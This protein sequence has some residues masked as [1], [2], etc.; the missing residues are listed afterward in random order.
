[1]A[2]YVGAFAWALSW[3]ALGGVTDLEQGA[4]CLA[5]GAYAYL[6]DDSLDRGEPLPA[7]GAACLAVTL[8]LA[9]LPA[10]PLV[11]GFLPAYKPLKRALPLAKPLYVAA[12]WTVLC[13]AIPSPRL[14]GHQAAAEDLAAVFLL[15]AALSNAA[16]V[17]D[18]EED[19]E[20]GI[21]TLPTRVG[22]RRALGV[23][24]V[25]GAGAVT[26][27]ALHHPDAWTT[28]VP[29]ASVV[30]LFV[31]TVR[32]EGEGCLADQPFSSRSHT[33]S[34]G[35]SGSRHGALRRGKAVGVRGWLG[36]SRVSVRST[37][38]SRTR[39]GRR[40]RPWWRLGV[41]SVLL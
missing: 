14:L 16:D 34:G 13:V 7:L 12:L 25:V 21:R 17:P 15:V 30:E 37:T 8:A 3:S 36:G 24:A 1:M 2:W 4:L 23:S 20:N 38:V 19:L 31:R 40:T 26:V 27:L 35:S 10:V 9:P 33:V 22:A 32:T 6:G 28:S 41:R 11:V 29:V 18:V 39:S 5:S